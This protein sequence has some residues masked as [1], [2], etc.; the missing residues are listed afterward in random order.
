MAQDAGLQQ[1]PAADAGDVVM[2]DQPVDTAAAACHSSTPA[3]HDD[4]HHDDSELAAAVTADVD[5][6][7]VS[8]VG[9]G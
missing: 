2:Q 5:V 8:Q 1:V 3:I 4:D 6:P 9:Y 7:P